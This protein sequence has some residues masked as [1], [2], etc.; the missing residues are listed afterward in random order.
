MPFVLV[1]LR[2]HCDGGSGLAVGAPGET[3]L[4]YEVDVN[5]ANALPMSKTASSNLGGSLDNALA[6]LAGSLDI[7]VSLLGLISLPNLG[8]L[9]HQALLTLLA[10]LLTQLATDILDTLDPLLSLLGIKVG[11]LDVQLFL[12]PPLPQVPEGIDGPALNRPTLLK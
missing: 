7:R 12:L 5:D 10:P 1:R 4:V 11:F 8:N 6:G 3:D 2:C 9:I